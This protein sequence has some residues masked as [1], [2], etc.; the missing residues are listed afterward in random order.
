MAELEAPDNQVAALL[1]LFQKNRILWKVE[2]GV[3]IASLITG[4]VQLILVFKIL[5]ILRGIYLS[6]PP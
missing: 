3:T 5:S 4:V 2:V 6:M 1:T